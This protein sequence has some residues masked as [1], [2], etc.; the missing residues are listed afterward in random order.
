MKQHPKRTVTLLTAYC[1]LLTV[2][3]GCESW[4][5]KFIRKS[6]TPP[7]RPSPVVNFQDYTNAMTPLDRY[8]KHFALYDYWN[9]QLLDELQQR[10]MNPKRAQ[11]AS[12]ESLQ[13]LG[14][15]Q[16]LLQDRAASQMGPLLE[17]RAQ[18]DRQIQREFYAPSQLEIIRQR[19][20]RQTRQINREW[21]WRKV[22]D[23][24]KPVDGDR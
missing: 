9:A 20:E 3:L 13:E 10:T 22:Q 1:L 16:Q 6:K 11:H 18:F 19:L 15:L 2:F 14:M 24:L 23:Q 8:R 5:Q 12:S 17:E 7:A 4:Q 21:F